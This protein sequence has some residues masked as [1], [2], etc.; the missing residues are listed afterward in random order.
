MSLSDQIL[1]I[2]LNKTLVYQSV[3]PI[4]YLDIQPS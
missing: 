2:T 4:I 3:H 1:N